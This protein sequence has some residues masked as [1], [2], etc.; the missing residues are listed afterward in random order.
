MKN[1]V[2]LSTCRPC[3]NYFGNECF[4]CQLQKTGLNLHAIC[5]LNFDKFLEKLMSLVRAPDCCWKALAVVLPRNS[6]RLRSV[7]GKGVCKNLWNLHIADKP[8][9]A[10]FQLAWAHSNVVGLGFVLFGFGLWKCWQ[11]WK[12]PIIQV[13]IG[14]FSIFSSSLLFIPCCFHVLKWTSFCTV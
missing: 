7:L 3:I 10:S 13:S 9:L 12:Y 2:W 1:M 4:R 8:N 5:R 14:F 6:H 11:S